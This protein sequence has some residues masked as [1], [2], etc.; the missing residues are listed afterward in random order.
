MPCRM[1]HSSTLR[2]RARYSVKFNNHSQLN[3][4]HAFLSASKYHWLNYSPDKLIE[5]FRTSQ[6]AA[7]GTRLH[8]LAA[9]HIRLKMRMPRNKV[10]F[11]NYVNDAIGFRMVP[12]QVLFYSVNCFGTADAISF[13]K[14]LL[15]IHDLKT[16]VHPAKVDQ[17]MIYAAL[18]CLEY[19]ERP[20]AI[21]Y[22][23]RIYQNDDIQ[24]ANPE[25]EDIAR[26][27]D[28]IIQFDK[29]IEKIKEE[30]A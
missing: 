24:V 2:T 22:E 25:G 3:G 8:E 15:R 1:Q 13:D 19:D 5:S 26:I 28:T 4:A 20:G 10:T 21:N 16:G 9:E 23:L 11:N 17:L 6:A 7:K 14:G 29:L 27:M 12:E 18:F 30:E